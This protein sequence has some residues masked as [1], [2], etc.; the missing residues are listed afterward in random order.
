MGICELCIRCLMALSIRHQPVP[1]ENVTTE[2][3]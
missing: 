1:K 3:V 2:M